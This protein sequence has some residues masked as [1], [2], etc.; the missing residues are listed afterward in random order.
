MTTS[1][2]TQTCGAVKPIV[3]KD[4]SAGQPA[5]RMQARK[6]EE[7]F[8]TPESGWPEEFPIARPSSNLYFVCGGNS[9]E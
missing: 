5:S 9:R 7:L 2:E 1:T 6:T 4:R 3:R 8:S